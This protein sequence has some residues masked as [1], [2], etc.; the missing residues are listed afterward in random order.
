MLSITDATLSSVNPS[1]VQKGLIEKYYDSLLALGIKFVEISPAVLPCLGAKHDLDRIITRKDFFLSHKERK[2][3]EIT[4]NTFFANHGKIPEP[5]LHY[6]GLRIL[7]DESLL[8]TDYFYSFAEIRESSPMPVTFCTKNAGYASTA[9]TVEWVLAGGDQIVCSFMGTG[10]Y[11]PLEEV[12]LALQVN[13]YPLPEIDM[14]QLK[15]LG[16]LWKSL[17]KGT[18]P[19]KKPI[20]GDKIFEVESGIHI[21]GI[22]KNHMNYEP[23]PPEDVGAKRE[24][25]L[26]KSSGRSALI[27]KMKELKIMENVNDLDWILHLVRQKSI[28]ENRSVCDTE[29]YSLIRNIKGADTCT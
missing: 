13:G 11:A 28:Y 5:Y 7:G 6:D 12:L 23:F 2:I 15:S 27:M 21:N 25:I 14:T 4:A 18:I 3:A 29:L 22:M 20:V 9:L 8:L 19:G 26:G 17:T 16:G 10:G 24:F 1:N